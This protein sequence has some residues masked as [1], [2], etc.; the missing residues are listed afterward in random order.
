[1]KVNKVEKLIIQ[2]E[3]TC[4]VFEETAQELARLRRRL[5]RIKEKLLAAK[6]AEKVRSLSV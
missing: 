2:Y 3:T 1:M 5:E 6:A 4:D